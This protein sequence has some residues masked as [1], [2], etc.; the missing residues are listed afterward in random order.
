MKLESIALHHG[1]E[2]EKN[3]QKAPAPRA[4]AGA[5]AAAPAQEGAGNESDQKA[6]QKG[7]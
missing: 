5:A 6:T 2:S 1:Y 4:E 3:D 7:G